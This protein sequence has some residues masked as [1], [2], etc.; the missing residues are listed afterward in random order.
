[1]LANPFEQTCHQYSSD[2]EGKQED[3]VFKIQ[4]YTGHADAYLTFNER[5]E[6]EHSELIQVRAA[7]GPS[8]SIVLSATELKDVNDVWLCVYAFSAYSGQ[9][10]VQ[11]TPNVI[12][13]QN[14]VISTKRMK[15]SEFWYGKFGSEQ[16]GNLRLTAWVEEGWAPLMAYKLCEDDCKKEIATL[17]DLPLEEKLKI[18]IPSQDQID[19]KTNLLDINHNASGC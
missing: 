18:L 6:D 1:M 7:K 19:D 16:D 5:P 4:A 2:V 11:K 12:D 13:L 17:E 9:V 15:T 10:I 8:T 14:G 3:L